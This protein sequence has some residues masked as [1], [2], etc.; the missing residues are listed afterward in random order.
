[1]SD[2]EELAF[3]ADY[4][5]SIEGY[6][7]LRKIANDVWTHAASIDGLICYLGPLLDSAE[8][9][10]YEKAREIMGTPSWRAYQLVE[11]G[12]LLKAIQRVEDLFPPMFPSDDQVVTKGLVIEAIKGDM[13]A[14]RTGT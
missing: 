13:D 9:R 3:E 2:P 4:E 1:M 12:V 6:E 8:K 10:G 7:E 14:S 11:R 5:R